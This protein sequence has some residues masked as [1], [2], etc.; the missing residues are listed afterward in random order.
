MILALDNLRAMSDAHVAPIELVSD[1]LARIAAI[2]WPVAEADEP[3]LVEALGWT[4]VPGTEGRYLEAETGWPINRSTADFSSGRI[5]QLTSISFSVTDVV[6]EPAP[7]RADFL[8]DALAEIVTAVKSVL[9]S[10]T[11]TRR[12]PEP[13]AIW[14]LA[15]G[16]RITIAIIESSVDVIAHSAEYAEVM[17]TLSS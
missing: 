12:R 8:N 4:V 15:N 3:A 13:E 5:E 10:P 14:K 11:A 17:D 1:V 7:W 16:G 2:T 9:G 6:A